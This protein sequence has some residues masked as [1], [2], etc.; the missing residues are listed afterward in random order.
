MTTVRSERAS[1]VQRIREVNQAAF[2]TSAEA[3]LVGLLR[4]R[5][6]LLVSLVAE[7]DGEIVGHIAFSRVYLASN[8]GL[9]GLG[10]GPTAVIP[11]HQRQGIGSQLVRAGLHR[12]A[13]LGAQ[14]VVVLGHP[15]YYP[16]FGFFP[17]SQFRLSCSWPVPEGVFMAT[18]LISG[19]L[20]SAE[21]LVSYEPEFNDV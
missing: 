19:A 8:P 1:D 16:R 7:S 17:A 5:G 10:L 12:C 11:T 14:F 2:E 9:H 15:D 13:A 20:A 3:S 6:K 21:G 4:E 18:E